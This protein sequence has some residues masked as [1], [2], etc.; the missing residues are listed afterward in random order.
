VD[1][2]ADDV[3]RRTATDGLLMLVLM[4]PLLALTVYVRRYCALL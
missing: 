1:A 3:K 4:A 2:A